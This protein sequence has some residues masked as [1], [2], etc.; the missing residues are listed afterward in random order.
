MRR[1]ATSP[2]DGAATGAPR[3]G[4]VPWRQGP[5]T[6]SAARRYPK[7]RGQGDLHERAGFI[8]FFYVPAMLLGLNAAAIALVARGHSYAWVGLLFGIAVL[9][10]LL[11][12][13]V[14]PY[15]RAWNSAH[16]DVGKDAA[17]GIVYELNN[18]I[19]LAL[20]PVIT[21]FIPCPAIDPREAFLPCAGRGRSS[22]RVRCSSTRRSRHCPWSASACRAGTRWRPACPWG[23]GCGAAHTSS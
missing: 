15:E 20:L 18:V 23:S 22:G 21:L 16:D 13:R 17:H 7:S 9:F 11:A 8:R 19:A 12:E 5:S 10:S 1:S 4:H 14:L 3:R 2:G 6:I